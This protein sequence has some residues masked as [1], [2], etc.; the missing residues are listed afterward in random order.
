[1][2]SNESMFWIRDGGYESV[3]GPISAFLSSADTIDTLD[4]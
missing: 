4:N 3:S 1:M 2:I